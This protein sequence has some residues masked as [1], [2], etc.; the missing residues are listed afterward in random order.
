MISIVTITYNNYEEL[1]ETL[2][3]I[4]GISNIESVVI[5]GGSCSK[6]REFLKTYNGKALTEKDEGI[7]DAFNKGIKLATGVAIMFLN[8]GD[9]LIDKDYI[10][11]VNRV[12]QDDTDVDFTFSNI[13][14]NNK[15][16][17]VC[18]IDSTGSDQRSLAKGMPY[19]HQT[20][21]IRKSILERVGG[22]SKKLKYAMDFDVVLKMKKIGVKGKHYNS[23]S[24]LM[25]G[26]GVSSKNNFGVIAETYYVLKYN[27]MISMPIFLRLGV[28]IVL[29]MSK[30]LLLKIGF[31]RLN[32]WIFLS[33]NKIKY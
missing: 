1:Q 15:E 27:K 6:T 25:D 28:S 17:G 16:Y 23:V 31:I 12:M 21:I 3:S 29:I 7:S 13:R 10:S 26:S 24:V 30:A 32:R 19:P 22:F 11:W 8:S 2:N 14:I 18:D 4:K 9:I 20:M 33:R 5:N